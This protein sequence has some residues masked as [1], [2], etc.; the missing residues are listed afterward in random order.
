MK[1]GADKRLRIA[2]L[3]RRFVSTAGAEK[4]GVEVARHLARDHE[5]H[6]FAQHFGPESIPG[7]TCHRL[8]QWLRKPRFVNQWLFAMQ[9]RRATAAGFDVVHSHDVLGHADVYTLH[10]PCFRSRYREV[11][12]TRQAARWIGTLLS[13]RELSYLLLERLQF[14]TR[15]H[16][17]RF[18]AV[19]DYM[20]RDVLA[21]YPAAKNA[22]LTAYPGLDTAG[23]V[24]P[25]PEQRKLARTRLEIGAN[26][27]VLLFIA[28]DFRKKGLASLLAALA[29]LKQDCTLLVAGGGKAEAFRGSLER[30]DRQVR[31]RFLGPQADLAPVFAAADLMAHPTRVDTYGMAVLEAM[32]HGLPVMVSNAVYCGIA[33][34]LDEDKAWLLNDPRDAEEIAAGIRRLH[35]DAGLRRRLAANGLAFAAHASW[36]RTADATLQAYRELIA[37]RER[38]T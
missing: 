21:T 38:V 6:V 28:N 5:V 1:T 15:H 10:V 22:L 23:I 27:F 18:L 12:G 35:A 20:R 26:T 3:I 17:K 32:A 7:I 16:P 4:Y 9:T 24:P 25:T 37:A 34:Q 14:S 8:R 19:S 11:T 30:L 31:V 33:E 29:R 13:P 2:V 36:A